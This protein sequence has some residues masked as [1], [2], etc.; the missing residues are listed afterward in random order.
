[1]AKKGY[2]MSET[3]QQQQTIQH[4][5]SLTMRCNIGKEGCS[6]KMNVTNPVTMIKTRKITEKSRPEKKLYLSVAYEHEVPF[7][8]YSFCFIK[9]ATIPLSAQGQPQGI[10]PTDVKHLFILDLLRQLQSLDMPQSPCSGDPLQGAIHLG[11]IL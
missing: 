2:I 9:E 8:D 11:R 5:I 10:A 7:C 6:G 1:M 4:E 3:T